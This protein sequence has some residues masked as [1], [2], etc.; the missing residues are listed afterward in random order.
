MMSLTLPYPEQMPA[1]LHATVIGGLNPEKSAFPSI[2]TTLRRSRFA[3]GPKLRIGSEL[4]TGGNGQP[5]WIPHN[6]SRVRA[7]RSRCEQLAERAQRE[8]GEGGP[9]ERAAHQLWLVWGLGLDAVPNLAE[10]LEE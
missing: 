6:S 7:C 10:F 4:S 9:T 2:R 5:R 3:G 8:A 1:E